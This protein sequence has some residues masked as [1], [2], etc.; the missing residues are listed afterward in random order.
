[1]NAG[2][3]SPGALSHVS[4]RICCRS[5]FGRTR[6]AL[7]DQGHTLVLG[8]WWQWLHFVVGLFVLKYPHPVPQLGRKVKLQLWDFCLLYSLAGLVRSL[9]K[10]NAFTWILQ[11]YW[12]F[13]AITFAG[14]TERDLTKC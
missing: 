3:H 4:S 11:R 8:S 9:T 12:Q 5:T 10:V 14:I 1:M 6:A 13:L 2:S 7:G